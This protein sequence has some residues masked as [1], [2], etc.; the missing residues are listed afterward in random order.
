ME[1]RRLQ[2]HIDRHFKGA[3]LGIASS[4]GS[5]PMLESK[6]NYQRDVSNFGTSS[7]GIGTCSFSLLVLPKTVWMSLEPPTP[8]S[9]G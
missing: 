9:N 4:Y 2:Q 1:R 5:Y 3:A 8:E 7:C 6:P